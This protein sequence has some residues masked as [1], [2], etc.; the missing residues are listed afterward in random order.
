MKR[1]MLWLVCSRR[2]GDETSSLGVSLL[3]LFAL[4]DAHMVAPDQLFAFLKNLFLY[5]AL[6][7]RG[8]VSSLWNNG[9]CSKVMSAPEGFRML[10]PAQ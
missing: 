9:I 3:I 4:I 7:K 2:R 10:T 1:P 5:T 8:R 6:H